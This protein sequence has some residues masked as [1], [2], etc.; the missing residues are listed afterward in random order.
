MKPIF[1]IAAIAF[2]FSACHHQKAITSASSNNQPRKDSAVVANETQT[3][4]Q[5]DVT[6]TTSD[7]STSATIVINNPPDTDVTP[8]VVAPNQDTTQE[9]YRLTVSF[10]SKGAGIDSKTEETFV[11]WL[12]AQPKQPAYEETRWGREGE[13][14]YCLKLSEL[15]TREQEIFV[16]DVRTLLTD[17]ELVIVSEYAPCKGRKVN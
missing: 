2:L 1:Y 4:T 15:S 12:K 17:K 11:K 3:H 9:I 6:I 8:T 13:K 5:G 14:N 16:R 10:I 7:Y